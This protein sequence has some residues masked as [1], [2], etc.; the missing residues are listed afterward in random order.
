M[1]LNI[2]RQ[3]LN[4][5]QEKSY[6]LSLESDLLLFINGDKSTKQYIIKSS[7]NSYYRLL[8]HQLC[9]YYNL[10]HQNNKSDEIIVTRVKK[11]DYTMQ[12]VQKLLDIIEPRPKLDNGNIKKVKNN[13]V[14]KVDV[15][16][17]D[18]KKADIKKTIFPKQLLKKQPTPPKIDEKTTES[19][20]LPQV[21]K[22]ALYMKVRQEIFNNEDEEDLSEL[23]DTETDTTMIDNSAN[24]PFYEKK[25][26]FHQRDNLQRQAHPVYP[27]SHPAY[28]EEINRANY[29]YP[30]YYHSNIPT[31]HSYQYNKKSQKSYPQQYPQA[32]VP[33]Q[34]PIYDTETERRML[35]NPYIII[36]ERDNNY[37]KK[38]YKKKG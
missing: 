22:K 9:Q 13:D 34:Y 35:N 25:E 27:L 8:A 38:N 37:Y 31:N 3:A 29:A 28:Y 4:K 30:P 2:L 26:K 21:D 17:T 6:L 19:I 23:S 32:Y 5:E 12:K 33:F 14:K 15:E 16:E 24:P 36:P 7:K 20:E 11:V 10:K 1:S 18:A